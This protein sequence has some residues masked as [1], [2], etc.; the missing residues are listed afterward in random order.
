MDIKLKMIGKSG[1]FCHKK[2]NFKYLCISLGDEPEEFIFWYKLRG[3]FVRKN[4]N[5]EIQDYGLFS[6]TVPVLV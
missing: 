3:I 4:Y 2:I 6:M 5:F 1:D